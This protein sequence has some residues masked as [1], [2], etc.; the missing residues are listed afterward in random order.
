FPFVVIG[1]IVSVLVA[2]FFR[3]EWVF[4]KLPK[5]RFFSHLYI[6][7]LG[8]FM[9]V[10]ECGNVPVTRRLMLKGFNLS[11]SVTF[12]LAA[13]ILN[14]ITLLTTWQ[15]FAPDANYVILRFIGALFIA[16]FIGILISF[17]KDQD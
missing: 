7:F 13:P 17:R 1:V 4:N 9:P 5:N 16:N 8:M 3:E 2:L 14:P 12:L 10:C 11:Q 6:S 15:A